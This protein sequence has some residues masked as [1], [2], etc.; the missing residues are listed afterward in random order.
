MQKCFHKKKLVTYSYS[1]IFTEIQ[2]ECNWNWYPLSMK[3]LEV[4]DSK[5]QW[6]KVFTRKNWN[7]KWRSRNEKSRHR[8][9]Q[10]SNLG[11]KSYD[12]MFSRERKACK[13]TTHSR[14]SQFE[15]KKLVKIF[16][17]T[18]GIQEIKIPS[19]HSSSVPK[20]IMMQCFHGRKERCKTRHI[21]ISHSC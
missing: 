16:V 5:S 9:I 12:A 1:M 11:S 6:S 4:I 7:W 3:N 17:K 8:F 10:R 14:K 13:D 21:L 18:L 15:R 2:V 20:K 19:I